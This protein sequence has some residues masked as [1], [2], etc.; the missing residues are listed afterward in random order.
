MERTSTPTAAAGSC[1]LAPGRKM[2]MGSQVAMQLAEAE[3]SYSRCVNGGTACSS[4][5]IV[6]CLSGRQGGKWLSR[7]FWRLAFTGSH[8][9]R[10]A[11]SEARGVLIFG[12]SKP[13]KYAY[14]ILVLTP[15]D[16]T[17]EKW[18]SYGC[19]HWGSI[20]DPRLTGSSPTPHRTGCS[21]PL[22]VWNGQMCWCMTLIPALLRKKQISLFEFLASL[23]YI[24][25]S[26]TAKAT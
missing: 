25:S 12:S 1:G 19:Q 20:S 17:R 4:Q 2:C 10:L 6:V 26:G 8:L 18:V 22:E 23:V 9:D 11:I 7:A 21:G 15:S 16:Q 24:V 14:M 13:I 3:V 5:P